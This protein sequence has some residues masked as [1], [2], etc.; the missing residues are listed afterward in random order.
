MTYYIIKLILYIDTNNMSKCEKH[1]NF[2]R[3]KIFYEPYGKNHCHVNHML[4]IGRHTSRSNSL[5]GF[6]HIFIGQFHVK[7][8]LS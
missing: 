1:N 5:S 2:F 8:T 6:D 7:V 3:V 4:Y